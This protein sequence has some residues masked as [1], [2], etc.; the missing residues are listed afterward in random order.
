MKTKD[1]V[2]YLLGD[3]C[4]VATTI[5]HLSLFCFPYVFARKDI[6]HLKNS[7]IEAKMKDLNLD[8]MPNVV[9]TVDCK[10]IELTLPG[11]YYLKIISDLYVKAHNNGKWNPILVS[12]RQCGNV[13]PRIKMEDYY[14]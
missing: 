13:R 6:E 9:V 12:E 11:E 10:A 14:A 3:E 8:L 4:E 7:A 1:V 2:F 5:K